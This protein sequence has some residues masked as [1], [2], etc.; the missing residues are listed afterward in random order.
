MT[1]RRYGIVTEICIESDGRADT[2]ERIDLA[3]ADLD[4]RAAP[5]RTP[6]LHGH[7]VGHPVADNLP[8]CS[9]IRESAWA[10]GRHSTPTKGSESCRAS[11]TRRNRSSDFPVGK[12]LVKGRNYFHVSLEI[13]PPHHR[14]TRPTLHAGG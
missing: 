11:S 10:A 7:P 13:T 14:G 4:P 1:G 5:L 2:L 6:R 9:G 12:A 3:V 8:M